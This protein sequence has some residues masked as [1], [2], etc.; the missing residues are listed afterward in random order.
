MEDMVKL[1]LELDICAK[2]II[3]QLRF[4]NENIEN[5]VAKGLEKAINDL[6]S[7]DESFINYVAETTK[8][9]LDKVIKNIL[10]DWTLQSKIREKFQSIIE[11]KVEGIADDLVKKLI[12]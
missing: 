6:T 9:E 7:S 11:N 12:D 2:K 4:D 5:L 1:N 8:K 10:T 3:Q